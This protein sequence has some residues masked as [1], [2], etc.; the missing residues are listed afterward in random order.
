MHLY[1]KYAFENS[2]EAIDVCDRDGLIIDMNRTSE[3]LWGIKREDFINKYNFFDL[4]RVKENKNLIE[5]IYKAIER[6]ESQEVSCYLTYNNSGESRWVSTIIYP[7]FEEETNQV[8]HFIVVNDNLT[9]KIKRMNE[10]EKLRLYGEMSRD[11]LQVLNSNETFDHTLR[12]ILN[13]LKLYTNIDSIGIRYIDSDNNFPFYVQHNFSEYI[14]NNNEIVNRINSK[15]LHDCCN[16]KN[17]DFLTSAGS[18]WTSDLDKTLLKAKDLE[19]LYRKTSIYQTEKYKSVAILRIY[20]KDRIVGFIHLADKQ[21]D[22]FNFS[23]IEVL[24]S[25]CANIGISLVRKKAEEDL[26]RSIKIQADLFNDLLYKNYIFECLA[27]ISK[28]LLECSDPDNVNQV[29][30]II[31]ETLNAS[32]SYI[33]EIFPLNNDY[34]LNYKYEWCNNNIQSSLKLRKTKISELHLQQLAE[35]V[36][37]D[38]LLNIS[39]TTNLTDEQQQIF[40]KQNVKAIL[41]TPVYLPNN[42]LYGYI[43]FDECLNPREWKDCEISILK[44]ISNL[45]GSFIKKC[46]NERRINNFIQDQSLILNNLD[47]YVWF[48]RT[49]DTYGFI[50]DKYYNDFIKNHDSIHTTKFKDD[51]L[52]T[53]CHIREESDEHIQTNIQIFETNKPIHY[54]QWVTNTLNQKRLLDIKKMPVKD[55]TDTFINIVCIANDI[56]DKYYREKELMDTFKNLFDEQNTIIDDNISQIK[57]T[58]SESSDILNGMIAANN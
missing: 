2:P 18:F 8:E 11:I 44:N 4:Y 30:Q 58:M 39:D 15:C 17:Y 56:T 43:G 50:N 31:G 1:Y 7:L 46:S 20:N 24:Q 33:Y 34:I 38:K 37:E 49:V 19:C 13:T 5:S 32:R 35:I 28:L 26:K 40:I 54:K 27:S 42:T 36:L 10:V 51:C 12:Q 9:K 41:L 29:L 14:T 55:D 23:I 25:I 16:P 57:Q 47:S 21:K 45:I 52:L 3:I 53:D 48:F 6:N 22:Y